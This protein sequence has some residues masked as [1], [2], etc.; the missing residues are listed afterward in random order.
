[1][2]QKVTSRS[3]PATAFLVGFRQFF[4]CFVQNERKNATI[5]KFAALNTAELS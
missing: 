5:L 2:H 1:M 3:G 4:D